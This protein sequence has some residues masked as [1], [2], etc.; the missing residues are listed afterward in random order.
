ML[1]VIPL[2]VSSMKEKGDC[3]GK[4]FQPTSNMHFSLPA[5]FLLDVV[6]QA[7][8]LADDPPLACLLVPAGNDV[9]WVS[10]NNHQSSTPLSRLQRVR[11]VTVNIN[12]LE[13]SLL[14]TQEIQ[15]S[16]IGKLHGAHGAMGLGKNL[17]SNL[18]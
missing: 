16:I 3:F 8:L 18:L 10:H 4:I 7:A 11:F 2:V 5:A 13:D 15:V 17:Q 1:H 6:K 12:H 14:F 9:Y